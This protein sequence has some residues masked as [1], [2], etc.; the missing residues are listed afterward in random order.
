MS[1]LAITERS[2]QTLLR[3]HEASVGTAGADL[4]SPAVAS[5]SDGQGQA[6]R[7]PSEAGPV[8]P[9]HAL[10]SQPGGGV[11]EFPFECFIN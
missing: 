1:T 8:A 10:P 9:Q 7:R 3:A 2:L 5:C 6:Q 11:R 4:P